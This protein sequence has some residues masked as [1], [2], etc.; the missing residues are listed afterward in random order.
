MKTSRK[1]LLMLV[2]GASLATTA[3][4][5]ASD[6]GYEHDGYR[7]WHHREARPVYYG[8]PQVV[9]A[10]ARVYYDGPPEVVY[11]QPPVAYG[12][13]QVVYNQPYPAPVYASY[14]NAGAVGGAIAGAV[15]GSRF[16]RGDGRVISTAVGTV[17]GSM[18]GGRM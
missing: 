3:P 4:A 13:P 8:P 1:V 6:W 15:I 18:I 5:F 17:L 9:Y 14:S 11:A 10:P 2:A 12:P 16:G 7:H